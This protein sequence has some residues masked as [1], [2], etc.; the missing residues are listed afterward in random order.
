MSSSTNSVVLELSSDAAFRL[1]CD[2]TLYPRWL[3]GAQEIRRID[4]D[5][6]AAGSKFAHRIGIGP[7]A[8]PGSTTVR[9]LDA[10]RVLELAAGMGV[11]GESKVRFELV[12]TKDGTEVRIVETPRK[13]L[14]A[15]ASK[16]L[17]PLVRGAL[18]GRNQASLEEL[19][20]VAIEHAA[21]SV[22]GPNSS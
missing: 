18:W 1:V 21:D 12:P 22:E 3:V 5:W 4:A 2:P 17:T 16:L 14:A 13:G 11:L 19:G 20:R 10:P 8:I 15:L 6:P 9:Q 7:L